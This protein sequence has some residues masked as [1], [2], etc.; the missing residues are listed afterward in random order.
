MANHG[1]VFPKG[2]FGMTV[3]IEI[4]DGLVGYQFKDGKSID[5]ENGFPCCNMILIFPT[6]EMR[7]AFHENFKEL[8]ESVKELL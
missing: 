1:R 3:T 4:K 7:D 5:K 8:I 6:E 2:V